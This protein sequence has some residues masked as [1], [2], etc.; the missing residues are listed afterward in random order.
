MTDDGWMQRGAACL[1]RQA[2]EEAVHAFHQAHLLQ[3]DD[4]YARFWLGESLF[5]AGRFADAAAV[6]ADLD[7]GDDDDLALEHAITLGRALHL[8]GHTAQAEIVLLKAFVAHPQNENA[9]YN[10]AVFYQQEGQ[11]AQAL[12]FLEPAA[13]QHPQSVRL[14]YNLGVNRAACGM[15]HEALQAFE[16]TLRLAPTHLQAH[17]NLA[18]MQLGMGQ[19]TTGWAHYAW[20]FNRH[21]WEG[22]PP[23]WQPQTAVLPMDLNGTLIELMGEQG[24]GDELFFLRFLPALKSR[25]A[26]VT[27][28]VG[29]DRLLSLLAPWVTSGL[30]DQLVAHNAPRQD[31]ALRL[32]AG[33]LP[34]ALG[35]RDYPPALKLQP[36]PQAM[37]RLV[38]KLPSLERNPQR[39][40]LGLTW[41]AGTIQSATG[42]GTNRWLCKQIPLT[43]LL[44]VLRPLDVDVMVLQ[45]NP[46]PEELLAIERALGAHRCLDASAIDQDLE[47]LLALLSSVDSLVGVSNTNVHLMAAMGKGGCILVPHPPEFRWQYEGAHSP[48]FAHFSVLRQTAQDDWGPALAQ[49]QTTLGSRFPPTSR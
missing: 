1:E 36:T 18:L 47:E 42:F 11:A 5:H 2:F 45:R 28:R 25:G 43:Q 6:L 19:L 14:H 26:T 23:H 9:A 12:Q 40:R 41:R 16:Q 39:P 38:Q 20:R 34:F 17:Q 37:A 24:L 44:E 22:A 13:A 48:W 32:L 21:H 49:L 10:L 3:P 8:T 31:G 30:L 33:D 27:Y 7:P 35:A 46:Q 15:A 4:R 29:N